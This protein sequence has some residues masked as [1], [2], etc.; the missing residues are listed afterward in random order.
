LTRLKGS[1][2]EKNLMAASAGESQ[3]RSRDTYFAAKAK[4]RDQGTK[5]ETK[6]IP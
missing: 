5:T 6:R 4:N 2:A 1:Q 3:A